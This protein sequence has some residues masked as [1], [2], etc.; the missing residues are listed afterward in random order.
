MEQVKGL[1]VG[2][3][4]VFIIPALR[5]LQMVQAYQLAQI[6]LQEHL[7]LFQQVM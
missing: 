7:A 1:T 3:E 5:A 4:V 6:H 2:M